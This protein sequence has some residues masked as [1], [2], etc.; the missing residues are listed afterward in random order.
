MTAEPSGAP[1]EE[2][3][4]DPAHCTLDLASA[5]THCAKSLGLRHA[6]VYLS[7]IQQ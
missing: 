7:D 5:V 6:V 2:F 1:L 3:L 4:A